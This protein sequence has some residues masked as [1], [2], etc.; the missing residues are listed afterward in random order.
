MKKM[1]KD[2]INER[3]NS[4]MPDAGQPVHRLPDDSNAAISKC[5]KQNFNLLGTCERIQ[6]CRRYISALFQLL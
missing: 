1:F 5:S 6:T 3:I 2:C 4:D